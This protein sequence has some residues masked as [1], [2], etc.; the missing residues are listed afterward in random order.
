MLIDITKKWT[1]PKI[2]TSGK[3]WFV[4]FRF[5]DETTK[6]WKPIKRKG[7]ANYAKL[8]KRERLDQLHTL[9][10]AIAY[11]LEKL[12]W[13]PV[14]DTCI[15]EEEL[16]I[17]QQLN[18]LTTLSL[19]KAID[20]AME[21]KKVGW[22]TKSIRCY[23]SVTKYI[24]QAA[25]ELKL[26][27]KLMVEFKKV[28]FKVILER[29]KKIRNLSPKGYNKYRRYLNGLINELVEWDIIESNPI[30]NIKTMAVTKT[31]AHRPPT[32]EERAA[33]M[34][35]LRTNYPNFYRFCFTMYAT[36]IRGKEILGLQVKDLIR[37]QQ[38]FRIVPI[39]EKSKVKFEREAVIPNT[40]MEEL[41]KLGLES[42]NPD[43]YIFSKGF[44]PGPKRMH[45]NTPTAWW[46]KIVKEVLKIN[47]D[48]YSLKK[49]GGDDMIRQGITL[50]GVSGQM[51]HTS[52]DTTEIYVTEHKRI[53]KEM[54]R[55]RMPVL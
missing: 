52:L 7:G 43:W 4:W 37:S 8:S 50:H 29:V 18:E 34:E 45:A 19:A 28:H 3:E 40:L 47:V 36:S 30:A 31:F 41:N 11:K 17:D 13:N 15:S 44:L 14:T 2:S 10:Q 9:R 26:A 53:Y 46:F 42:C 6:S 5:Y 16:S 22:A 54:I 21:K 25:T 27:G 1:E 33:I 20:F 23:E 48:L 38:L 39:N 24:L 32:D 49:L 51:G 55:E 35:H 12:G